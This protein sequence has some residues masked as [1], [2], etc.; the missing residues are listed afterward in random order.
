MKKLL[1]IFL[2]LTLALA[3]AACGA[4]PA[5]PAPAEETPAAPLEAAAQAAVGETGEAGEEAPAEEPHYSDTM[6][7]FDQLTPAARIIILENT[8]NYSRD[9][10]Y[11]ADTK[12]ATEEI[13]YNGAAA[14]AYPI[15]Y[16]TQ[17]LTNGLSGMVKV[18]D[19]EGVVHEL[20]A[21]D[22]QALYVVI[23]FSSGL[24][25]VVCA[26]DGSGAINF[27]YAI[28]EGGEGIYSVPAS[29][30]HKPLD[31]LA[32]Y[33]WP[34]E[35]EYRYVATDKFHI[36]V[37]AAEN[38]TGELRGALSGAVNGSFPDLALASGKINDVIFIE[39]IQ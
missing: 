8:I 21:E 4:A 24:A 26:A 32:V 20:S 31:V 1:V 33:G 14:Q 25:P 17:F 12:P 5:E 6:V 29:T 7:P 22:F 27:A 37:P 15:S 19:S 36:P 10:F 3:L 11:T 2:T 9:G 16:A 23:D 13:T 38:S 39:A 35:A 18:G 28:T 30:S 34:A